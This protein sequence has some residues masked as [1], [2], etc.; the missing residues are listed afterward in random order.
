[1]SDL[2]PTHRIPEESAGVDKNIIE[3]DASLGC[4]IPALVTHDID[5]P[6]SADD[7]TIVVDNRW[8]FDTAQG[9]AQRSRGHCA[10]VRCLLELQRSV[11]LDAIR[12]EALEVD[13]VRACST[14]V[15]L[16]NVSGRGQEMYQL[17][18]N[19][20]CN[21]KLFGEWANFL[22]PIL[23]HPDAQ[24]EEFLAPYMEQIWRRYIKF[25]D[26]VTGIFSIL[27]ENY[28]HR[29][30]FPKIGRFVEDTFTRRC[31][32]DELLANNDLF[33]DRGILHRQT[34]ID[35]RKIITGSRRRH[36]IGVRHS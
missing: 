13:F 26:A 1:M 8:T 11:Q 21:T 33:G 35:L 27:D 31:L 5:T 24:V 6:V 23:E 36:S 17:F 30:R 10:F 7:L 28:V 16:E 14:F 18:T 20:V 34:M 22:R 4:C 2:S 15:K 19:F 3:E 29:Y 32:P 12:E 9:I 25:K